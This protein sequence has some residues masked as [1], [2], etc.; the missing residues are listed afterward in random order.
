[1]QRRRGWVAVLAGL[2]GLAIAL[3]LGC[4]QRFVPTPGDPPPEVAASPSPTPTLVMVRPERPESDLPAGIQ[5]FRTDNAGQLAEDGANHVIVFDPRSPALDFKVNLGIA[6]PL[7]AQNPDG[8][9]RREYVPKRFRELVQDENAQL[10]GQ[11]PIAA[12]NGDYIDVD[13]TPQGL[14]VSRGVEYA[15]PFAE[16]RS[17]FAISG[18]PPETRQATIAVGRRDD[19]ALQ[20][21]AVGG[22]GRFYRQGEF[23]DICQ[24]LGEMA[25]WRETNRSMAAIAASGQVILLVNSSTTPEQVLY[26]HQFDEVLAGI[27]ERLSLGP[28]QE[29]MLLDGGLSTA[30]YFNGRIYVENLN[31]MGS[32]LLI[33]TKSP[34]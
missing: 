19:P 18:G 27:S 2:V 3:G 30:L 5:F 12:I 14:N 25:C 23:R 31:P 15:G 10:E 34:A 29:A 7:Y 33:Y 16:Q 26:P 11:W 6:H 22:N 21:N 13:D 9:L 32:V 8:S 17:S 4:T 20:F 24:D 28:I 1:M